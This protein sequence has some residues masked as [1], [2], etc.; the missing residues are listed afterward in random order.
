MCI[1]WLFMC[2]QALSSFKLYERLIIES[3]QP[4]LLYDPI[5]LLLKQNYCMS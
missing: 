5:I 1:E 2:I 3:D 4:L